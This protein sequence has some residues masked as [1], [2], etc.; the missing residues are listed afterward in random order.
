MVQVWPPCS[1]DAGSLECMQLGTSTIPKEAYGI[2]KMLRGK[3][4]SCS[5]S[6]LATIGKLQEKLGVVAVAAL[7][8]PHGV[9]WTLSSRGPGCLSHNSVLR[10][11]CHPPSWDQTL[12]AG[13][14]R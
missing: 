10:T 11:I 9:N 14:G 8:D 5:E 1:C 3:E 12:P 2:A 7:V 13:S 4:F 6:H